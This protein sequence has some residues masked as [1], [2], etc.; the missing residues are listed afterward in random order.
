MS[1]TGCSPKIIWSSSDRHVS[2][3]ADGDERVGD[4]VE[5]RAGLVVRRVEPLDGLGQA[6]TGDTHVHAGWTASRASHV[7]VFQPQVVHPAIDH[8]RHQQL[9][10]QPDIEI[11]GGGLATDVVHHRWLVQLRFQLAATIARN[12][13]IRRRRLICSQ[14]RNSKILQYLLQDYNG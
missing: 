14:G 11:V 3:I 7:V 8:E 9:Q 10:V 2:D 13:N 1:L 6:P 12:C 5:V 4:G